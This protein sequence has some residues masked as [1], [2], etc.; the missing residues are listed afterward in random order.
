MGIKDLLVTVDLSKSGQARIDYA[1]GLAEAHGAHLIGVAYAQEART[2][3]DGFA[4]A[5]ERRGLS[6]ET[7]LITCKAANL[8]DE[9][10]LHARHVDVAVIGQPEGE[11]GAGPQHALLNALLFFAGRP[12]LLVPWAGKANPEPKTVMVGWD[13]SGRAARALADALPILRRAEKVVVVVAIGDRRGDHGEEPGADI[14]LH[15]ARHGIVSEA[16]R[17][18]LGL[19]VGVADLLLSQ[20][21]DLGA[22]MIVMGGYHHSRL[23]ESVLGGVTGTVLKTMTVPVLMSH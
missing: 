5:S 18:P 8:P 23:R 7:R 2:A 12:L 20:A 4:K 9:M 3:L 19:D 22:E 13:A 10:A 14:T 11:D 15:L 21:T 1:F 16:C 17:I 6:A